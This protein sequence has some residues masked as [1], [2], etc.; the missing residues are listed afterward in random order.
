MVD[1]FKG[2][3]ARAAAGLS[4]LGAMFV[5]GV[6]LAGPSSAAAD[7]VSTAFDT[8]EGKITTYGG[9]LATLTVLAVGIML[10]LAW[11][12]KARSA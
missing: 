11:L 7:P 6:M 8:M 3:G 1:N 4:A 5:V 10:G 12:K 9:A 2:A